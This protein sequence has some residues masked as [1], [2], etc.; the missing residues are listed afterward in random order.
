MLVFGTHKG[1]MVCLDLKG[2]LIREIS[3]GEGVIFSTPFPI[4]RT[5]ERIEE[6]RR[7]LQQ[8]QQLQVICS[9]SNHRMIQVTLLSPSTSGVEERD[10][11][12]VEFKLRG[13]IFSSPLVFQDRWIIVGCRDD[14]LYMF[15]RFAAFSD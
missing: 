10:A 1:K 3:M 8:Q 13:E 5:Y 11:I 7:K 9:I 15:D 4:K 6:K 2:S 12:C 14:Y